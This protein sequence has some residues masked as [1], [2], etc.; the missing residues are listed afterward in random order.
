MMASELGQYGIRVNSINP[1]VVM[2]KLGK[3]SIQYSSYFIAS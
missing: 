2:T 3:E 1:T